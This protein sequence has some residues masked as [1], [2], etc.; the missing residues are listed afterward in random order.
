MAANNIVLSIPATRSRSSDGWTLQPVLGIPL[1]LRSAYV[2]AEAG[3]RKFVVMGPIRLKR[4]FQHL[5]RKTL[6]L[7]GATLRWISL[8]KEDQIEQSTVTK[9]ADSLDGSALLLDIRTVVTKQWAE[10]AMASDVST[11]ECPCTPAAV[12]PPQI[13]IASLTAACEQIK[14]NCSQSG[15]RQFYHTAK[16][17]DIP[18]LEA[19]LSENL[20]L[21]AKGLVSRHFN[22]RISIP[23]SR[24][25]A[26]ARIS[27]NVITAFNTCICFGAAIA[28]AGVT[29]YSLAW[30]GI[31]LQLASIFDGCDGEVAR[32]THRASK[33]GQALDTLGDNIGLTA[34]FI[35][36][37]IH[38]YR[39][40]GAFAWGWGIMLLTGLGGFISIMIRYLRQHTESMSLTAFTEA[41]VF[42]WIN[43]HRGWKGNLLNAG[44][45]LLKREWFSLI[46]C[47][48]GIL[49]YMELV[50]YIATVALWIGVFCALALLYHDSSEPS[51]EH[52]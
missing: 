16:P 39:T 34:F 46:F 31:L 14:Q 9:L 42:P 28:A 40:D 22:R 2:L 43:A 12:L 7:Q 38:H 11:G 20:R 32:L 3:H 5:W 51:P 8:S 15:G 24:W 41:I 48:L 26:R 44:K 29:N 13:S 45:A 37:M 17:A 33:R 35:G 21:A 27:P 1:A 47:L 36:L 50:L 52:S 19:F 49:G 6:A 25:L 4:R 18:G 23:V 30:S 10:Q